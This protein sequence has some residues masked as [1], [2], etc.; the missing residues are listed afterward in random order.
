LDN[1]PL[2]TEQAVRCSAVVRIINNKSVKVKQT[3][4]KRKMLKSFQNL[5]TRK[6]AFG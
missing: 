6:D 2:S 3:A 5:K 1:E 4:K